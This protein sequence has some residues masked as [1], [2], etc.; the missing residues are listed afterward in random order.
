MPNGLVRRALHQAL[1]HTALTPLSY[2]QGYTD[3]SYQGCTITGGTPGSSTVDGSLWLLTKYD[4]A[5]AHVWRNIGIIWG[6][7]CVFTVFIILGSTL[8]I[9]DSALTSG[10]K[11]YKRGAKV[12]AIP[13]ELKMPS[14]RAEEQSEK[15]KPKDFSNRATFTFRNVTYSVPVGGT[16]K[17][18]LN[19][20]TGVVKPGRLSA[21]MGASGE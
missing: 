7:T 13:K 11:I 5:S 20:I 19:G 3:L 4:Y 15:P 2:L 12:A 10:G 6:F 14:A 9:R 18:L 17:V 8:L 16:D 21:L 1:A